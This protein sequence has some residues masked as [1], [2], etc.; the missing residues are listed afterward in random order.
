M[1]LVEYL[2][3]KGWDKKAAE[4]I[5][6][7]YNAGGLFAVMHFIYWKDITTKPLNLKE[8]ETLVRAIVGWELE[9]D[10]AIETPRAPRE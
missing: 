2:K 1:T 8:P 6:F 3:E 10:H 4:E 7:V 5:Y 9:Y